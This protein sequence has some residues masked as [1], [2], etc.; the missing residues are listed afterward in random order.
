MQAKPQKLH[1]LHAWTQ[2]YCRFFGSFYEQVLFYILK[3]MYFLL[4]WDI[5]LNFFVQTCP[6]SKNTILTLVIEQFLF[7][8]FLENKVCLS[9]FQ[10]VKTMPF[11]LEIK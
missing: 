11:N 1:T 8:N 2:K 4:L 10:I 6:A 7:T 9:F 5:E 3:T